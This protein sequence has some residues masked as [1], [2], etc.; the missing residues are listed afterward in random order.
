MEEQISWEIPAH[1]DLGILSRK[2]IDVEAIRT[3]AAMTRDNDGSVCPLSFN[4]LHQIILRGGEIYY[5]QKDCC[6]DAFVIVE[7][8]GYIEC[9]KR[10]V[11]LCRGEY[12]NGVENKQKMLASLLG[13]I[14]SNN[15]D[16]YLLMDT[17]NP[18]LIKILQEY[19]FN[20]ISDSNWQSIRLLFHYFRTH[21]KYVLSGFWGSNR[22]T[23]TYAA[24]LRDPDIVKI[25]T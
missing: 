6:I 14:V 8:F 5:F 1:G 17:A 2:C 23:D 16:K 18:D 20:I 19:D 11:S 3:I 10:S 21:P 24:L 15:R 7:P 25:E 13:Y 4:E 12:V 22:N 9:N